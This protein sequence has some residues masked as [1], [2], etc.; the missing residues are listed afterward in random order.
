MDLMCVM[1]EGEPYGHLATHAGAMSV[2]YLAN[3]LGIRRSVLV[4]C[5]NELEKHGVSSVNSA[6]F[7][8]SRRMVRDEE[9]RQRR[10]SGG[11]LSVNNPNVPRSKKDIHQGSGEGSNAVPS[12]SSS[13]SSSSSTSNTEEQI[14]TA[15]AAAECET[16]PALKLVKAENCV[17]TWFDQEFWPEYPRKKAREAALKAAK[18]RAKTAEDR[19]EIMSGLRAQLPAMQLLDPQ[20]IPHAATF[21]NQQRWKDPP[22]LPPKTPQ[23]KSFASDVEDVIRSRMERGLSP[24]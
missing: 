17:V 12:P 22:E 3:Y 5:M 7:V 8:Y 19:A 11:P 14:H 23:Q 24:L 21:L 10:A 16:P 4:S 20:Y 15:A 18:A 13:S 2:S 9:L 6:G 1:H